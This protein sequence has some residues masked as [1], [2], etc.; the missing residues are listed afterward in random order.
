MG[1]WLGI[2]GMWIFCDGWISLAL[3]IPEKQSWLRDHSIR[4]IRCLLGIVL[5]WLGYKC[6]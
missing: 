4:I 2:I 6:L 1:Y 3:Y 5:M